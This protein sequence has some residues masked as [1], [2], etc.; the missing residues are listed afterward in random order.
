LRPPEEST[1]AARRSRAASPAIADEV[2]ASIILAAL[3]GLAARSRTGDLAALTE[4]RMAG[5][6][7]AGKR[8][9]DEAHALGGEPAALTRGASWR[10]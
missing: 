8:M 7:I 10:S 4:L 2:A 5:L 1:G 6:R 9:V 3:R